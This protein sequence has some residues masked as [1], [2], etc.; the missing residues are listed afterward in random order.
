MRTRKNIGQ[1]AMRAIREIKIALADN[2][3]RDD[4]F[5]ALGF[6][7]ETNSISGAPAL[8]L[9]RLKRDGCYSAPLAEMVS[10]TGRMADG[11]MEQ[12][13]ELRALAYQYGLRL[14]IHRTES[15]SRVGYV[16]FAVC[17]ESDDGPA[18]V[19]SRTPARHAV[20]GSAVAPDSRRGPLRA[21]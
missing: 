19:V 17:R 5:S 16:P 4:G 15:G 20:R 21:A 8:I 3:G 12:F 7:E 14:W 18:V 11:G 10:A 1:H 9:R 6:S 13:D 2:L